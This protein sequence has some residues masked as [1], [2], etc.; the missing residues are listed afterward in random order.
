MDPRQAAAEA[1]AAGARDATARP[2]QRRQFAGVD[3]EP[4]FLTALRVM[5]WT[6][7]ATPRV[8]RGFELRADAGSGGTVVAGLASVTETPYEMWDMFGPYTEVVALDAFDATLAA[9][10]LVEFTVNHGA[11][12]GKPM[13]HT[14]T[15]SLVLEAIKEA[16]GDDG[17][18]GLHYEATVNPARHDV[19]DTIIA[20]QDGDLAEASFKFRIVRGLWSPDWTQYRIEEV[21]LER[22]DVSA[23]NF[24]ANPFASSG[25]LTHA[26]APKPE[27]TPVPIST[28]DAARRVMIHHVD[29]RRRV[30]T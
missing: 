13:A 22:G 8:A 20:M 30:L 27:A 7:T 3:A 2:S 18:T 14:R 26:A 10:P 9:D 5:G 6:V 12:G 19:S 1:R 28:A 21:D 4:E 24:G 11:G 17:E 25:V 23:V 29:T 16:D 15:G